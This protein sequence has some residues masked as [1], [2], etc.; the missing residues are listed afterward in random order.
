G[1]RAA[2]SAGCVGAGGQ[3]DVAEI[4]Q[5]AVERDVINVAAVGEVADRSGWQADGAEVEVPVRLG[6]RPAIAVDRVRQR[7]APRVGGLDDDVDLVR[8][9]QLLFQ[10][11]RN[12]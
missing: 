3:R 1:R 6:Y 8:A 4:L 11:G 9:A 10:V 12:L 2:H 5:I 7:A